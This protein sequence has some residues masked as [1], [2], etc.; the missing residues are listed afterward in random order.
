MTAESLVA[1]IFGDQEALL[2]ALEADGWPRK[3]AAAGFLR[4]R[5]TWVV[6]D[7]EE[8][9]DRELGALEAGE[10][11]W[12]DR[13][14]HVW[15]ALPGAGVTPVLFGVL[16]GI[17]QVVRI[18]R[19]GAGFGE[20]FQRCA[21]RAGVGVEVELP[22]EEAGRGSMP[23]AEVYVVSGSDQTVEAVRGQVSGTVV[24]YG[25]RVS[26]GVVVDDGEVD[27]GAVAGEMAAD[28][29]LWNQRGCFS[30][31]GVLFDGEPPRRRRFAEEL[32]GAIDRREE[33]W[34]AAAGLSEGEIA[35]RAQ[36][37]GKAQMAGEVFCQGVGF[38]V[39]DDGPFR[40][41][42]V[43][44]HSVSV[45]GVAGPQGVREALALPARH[46][47]GVALAGAWSRDQLG[48][49]EALGRAGATRV[50]GAGELQAPE[51]GWWH[52]GRPNVLSWARAVSLSSVIGGA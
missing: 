25:H 39:I 34:G 48:W 47:Q 40:G 50:C 30:L 16:L 21:R 15:P 46:V 7:L 17:E 27:L 32:A 36:A 3:L 24:G 14:C 37:L 10:L 20:Y 29:V 12:P 2:T 49:I 38:V 41:R 26:F 6:R 19:R 1:E 42:Q 35:Q 4:H 23:T 13:V 28:G 51:A 18:S 22:Q 8:A 5:E 33:E 45:H 43:A 9:L 11:V 44:A 31:R 52:D